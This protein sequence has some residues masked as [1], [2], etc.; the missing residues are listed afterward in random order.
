MSIRE[1][2]LEDILAEYSN[3]SEETAQP[4]ETENLSQ[5]TAK[6][7]ETFEDNGETEQAFADEAEEAVHTDAATPEQAEKTDLSAQQMT[8]V[9]RAPKTEKTIRRPQ[10]D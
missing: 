10:K 3:F 2:D 1:Y 4:E 5:D 9:F 8:Q 6:Q 7:K